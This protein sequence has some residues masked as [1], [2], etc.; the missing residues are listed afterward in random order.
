MDHNDQYK[1][2]DKSIGHKDVGKARVDCGVLKH[3]TKCGFQGND[4]KGCLCLQITFNEQIGFNFSQANFE[5]TFS[6]SDAASGKKLE[7]F[8]INVLPE[9]LRCPPSENQAYRWLFQAS[10]KAKGS[11]YTSAHL[12]WNAHKP[13]REDERTGPIYFAVLI[14]NQQCLA[15]N[16][17]IELKI[18]AQLHGWYR[19]WNFF[20]R[21]SSASTR[22]HVPFSK[23]NNIDE[24]IKEVDRLNGLAIENERKFNLVQLSTI[25]LVLL[26]IAMIK[27]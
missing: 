17:Q 3:H 26:T 7:E 4:C 2:I 21:S 27:V 9:R 5:L 8:E 1:G 23:E 11:N 16:F 6:V 18:D 12:N 10:R 20:Q 24:P 19:I 22:I 25:L 13:D 15:Y 14:N